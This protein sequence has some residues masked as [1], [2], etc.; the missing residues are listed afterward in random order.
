MKEVQEARFREDLFYRL[1]VVPIYLPPLK[2]RSEDVPLLVDYYLK[3]YSIENNAMVKAISDEAMDY[4]CQYDWPGNVRELR[5]AIHR[6]VVMGSN[7]VLE[8]EQI[9]YLFSYK[10]EASSEG[11]HS[12]GMAIEDVEKDLIYSTLEKPVAIK[13]RLLNCLKLQQGR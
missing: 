1:N 8:L 4:L 5:N 2:E 10:Q 9:N 13:P 7:E 11:A 12:T 3:K 6:A